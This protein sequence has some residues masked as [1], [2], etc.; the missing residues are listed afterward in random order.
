MQRKKRRKERDRAGY[1]Q[2]T[3][4]ESEK[5]GVTETETDIEILHTRIDRIDNALYLR[6]E[7]KGRVV[8]LNCIQIKVGDLQNIA[9]HRQKMFAITERGEV[10]S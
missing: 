7:I 9:N 6:V 1:I 2:T 4:R 8:D 3:E 10:K 5:E